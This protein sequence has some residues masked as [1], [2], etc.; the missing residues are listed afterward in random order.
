MA[1]GC[2]A[3]GQTWDGDVDEALA[4]FRVHGAECAQ[5]QRAQI[6]EKLRAE[7][8]ERILALET[9]LRDEFTQA[10]NRHEYAFR[11][12]DSRLGKQ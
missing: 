11:Y 4:K 1:I 8:N 3:C 10:I 9:R 2:V 5:R 12:L 7:F 6:E